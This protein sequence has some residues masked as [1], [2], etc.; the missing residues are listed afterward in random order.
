MDKFNETRLIFSKLVV[1][2]QIDKNLAA[3]RVWHIRM[4]DQLTEK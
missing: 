4:N 1:I 3:L 2:K